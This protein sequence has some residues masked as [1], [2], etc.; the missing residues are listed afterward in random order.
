MADA[1][2]SSYSRV[3]VTKLLAGPNNSPQFLAWAVP[4]A[5]EQS[6]GDAERQ[7]A[8]SPLQYGAFDDIGEI[9]SGEERP[10]IGLRMIYTLSKSELLSLAQRRCTF[11]LQIHIGKCKDP[12]DH[13]RGWDKI[14]AYESARI[15]SYSTDDLGA[16]SEGDN[17]QVNEEAE[18]SGR[19]M[20]EILPMTA[21]ERAAAQVLQEVIKVLVC[22][23]PTC[24]DCGNPSDGCSTMF[25]ITKPVGSSPGLLPGVIFTDDGFTTPGS[26]VITTLSAA[27]SPS[28]AACVSDNL[29]VVSADTDSLHY[30]DKADILDGT[31]IWAEVTTGFVAAGSPN[32]ID[33]YSPRDTF[34]VGDAGYIYYSEDPIEGVTV[35]DAGNAT[36]E[37]LNAVRMFSTEIIVA[38]GDNNTVVYSLDGG[39]T[40]VSVTGPDTIGTPNLI[41]V[42]IRKESEWWVGTDDGKMYFTEDDGGSWEEKPFKNSGTGSVTSIVFASNFVGYMSHNRTGPANGRIFRTI[43]GGKTW[44]VWPEGTNTLPE[45]DKINSL[46]LC[47]LEV[48]VVVAGGL[49]GNAADGIIIKGVG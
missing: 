6:F 28:G 13:D 42:E 33:S 18:V 39:A 25:A 34:I 47:P 31:E 5:N 48:N 4:L 43:S 23:L 12:R 19:D 9:V 32:A 24:G 30:A 45:N 20:Y 29:V 14:L 17:A 40:W 7:T 3:F 41:S 27:E 11:D 22:D 37:N 10:T 38:V 15:G 35:S 2:R 36:T 16:L 44:Y 26:T 46:A 8:P 21:A 49:A 1:M